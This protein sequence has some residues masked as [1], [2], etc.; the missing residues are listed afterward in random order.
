LKVIILTGNE[1]YFTSW[2]IWNDLMQKVF[3][4][5]ENAGSGSLG[6]PAHAQDRDIIE[7][8]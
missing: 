4:D 2:L 3:R 5:P 7:K 8:G 1:I 6:K